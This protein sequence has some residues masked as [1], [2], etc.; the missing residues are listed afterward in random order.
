MSSSK[1][2]TLVSICVALALVGLTT[3][4]V[5]KNKKTTP[6]P[7][8]KDTG[9]CEQKLIGKAYFIQAAGNGQQLSGGRNGVLGLSTNKLSWERWTFETSSK[10]VNSLLVKNL[11]H[12]LYIQAH[13]N[14][15]V[16]SN[17]ENPDTWEAFKVEYLDDTCLK[18][19]LKSYHGKYVGL[20]AEKTAFV[21]TATTVGENETFIL[22]AA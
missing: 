12:N 11:Q 22:L 4:F 13:D 20:N 5:L 6:T 19:A 1:K 18:I 8:G 10:V 16:D 9:T 15:G 14:G 2:I 7:P 3:F 17:T 21:N